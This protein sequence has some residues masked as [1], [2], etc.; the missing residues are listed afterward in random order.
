MQL[1]DFHYHLPPELIAQ[2]PADQRELARLMTLDR[3]SGEIG[4]GVIADIADFFT[5]GDLL[6][7]NDTKVIPARLLGRKETGGK[8]E[9]FLARRVSGVGEVWQCLIKSSKPPVPGSLVF[10]AEGITAQVLEPYKQD[11]WLVSFRPEEGF[12]D[13]LD[14]IGSMP[15]PPYIRRPAGV[16]D[17]E[18]YQTV[19]AREKG[20]VAAPT[21]ALHFTE[22]LLQKI[23]V[24]GVDIEPLT[25][26]VGLGTFIPVRVQDLREHCMHT[27]YYRIPETTARAVT[28]RKKS[29][30]RVIALGTT[31]T[32]AME[33]ASAEDG[34][35]DAKEGEADIFILPGYKFKVVDALITNF[36]LPESTLLML[37][38]AFAG[39]G[40]LFNAYA[41]AIRRKFRFFSYGDAMFIY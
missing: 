3:S 11:T 10:L 28:D 18:R 16:V 30:K 31:T 39:Q 32:R 12:L 20:A 14:K 23:R 19:F 21:A 6:V 17:I 9:V 40:K 5:P 27:E 7:I 37:V 36:H 34:S 22:A 24:R 38:S 25:L 13:R 35:L 4:E 15:L 33:H 41:E 26:H 29:G 8:A 1:K 2:E